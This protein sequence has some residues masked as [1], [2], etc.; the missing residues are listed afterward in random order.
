MIGGNQPREGG[1]LI[2]NE[3]EKNKLSSEYPGISRFFRKL[4]GNTEFVNGTKMVHL[5]KSK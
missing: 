3:I 2:L 5:D 4:V 1:Y